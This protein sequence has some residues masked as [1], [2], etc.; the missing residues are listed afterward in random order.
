MSPQELAR[1]EQALRR[2]VH[3]EPKDALRKAVKAGLD[4]VRPQFNLTEDDRRRLRHP[5]LRRAS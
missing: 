2:F 5:R 1:H 3:P 4:E